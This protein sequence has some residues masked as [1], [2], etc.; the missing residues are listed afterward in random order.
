MS[1]PNIPYVDRSGFNSDHRFFVDGTTEN[2]VDAIRYL[3]NV[4]EYYELVKD[5]TDDKKGNPFPLSKRKA[6]ELLKFI[7]GFNWCYERIPE[8]QKI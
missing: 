7:N 5:A 4:A 8:S 2:L 6:N 1:K 3:E